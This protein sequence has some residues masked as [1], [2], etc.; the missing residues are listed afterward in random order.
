M[1]QVILFTRHMQQ[2]PGVFL[3]HIRI[4]NYTLKREDI[5]PVIH[6]SRR[7][8]IMFGYGLVTRRS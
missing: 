4:F 2:M 6:V 7:T 1:Y 5:S 3:A 8:A